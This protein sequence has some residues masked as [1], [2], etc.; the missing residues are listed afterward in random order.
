[1]NIGKRQRV[2]V[3]NIWKRETEFSNWLTSSDG[4]ELIEQ[5]LG[6]RIADPRREA[7][8][9]DFPCDIVG[10]LA[11]DE[12]HIVVVENQYGKTNHD[13]L[14][15][16]L[17]YA[18]VHKAMTGIWIAEQA[19]D[20]HRQVIDWLNQNTP[21]TVSLFLAEVKAYQIGDSAAAPQLDVVC[22]PNMTVKLTHADQSDAE[23]ARHTWRIQFWEEIQAEIRKRRPPFNLQKPSASH[24][25]SISIGRSGVNINMLLTPGKQTIGLDLYIDLPDWTSTAYQSLL[26]QKES[27]EA[28]LGAPLAWLELP[29]KRSSRILL[30]AKIDPK[31]HANRAIVIEWFATNTVKMYWAFR[32]KVLALRPPGE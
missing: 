8:M 22:Q 31:D 20:D 23:K 19:S 29:D 4:L 1:M 26:A 21:P 27:I 12:D 6:I 32:D 15:K 5:D 17:T 13:H 18:A 28:D 11:Q 7:R 3:K 30:E 10:H 24:W 9:G 25:S 16:L 2:D 14:G